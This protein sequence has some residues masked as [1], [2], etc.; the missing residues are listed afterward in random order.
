MNNI[1]ALKVVIKASQVVLVWCLNHLLEVKCHQLINILNMFFL[2]VLDYLGVAEVIDTM[3]D[4]VQFLRD[5]SPAL[6]KAA[7]EVMLV[8]YIILTLL[9]H[10]DRFQKKLKNIF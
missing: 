6:S 2:Q 7:R 10:L 4:L 3:E 8:L 5:I 1:Q 9:L